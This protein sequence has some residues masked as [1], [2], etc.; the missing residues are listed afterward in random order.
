MAGGGGYN[1]GFLATPRAVVPTPVESLE[2]FRVATNNAGAEFTRSAGAEVQMVT[3]RG[4]NS[5]HGAGYW[6]HQ[7]DELNA[8]NWF[9]N[10]G[11]W[12]PTV[13]PIENPEW[14]D[15]RYG[16]KI[17][18][19]IWKNRTFFFLHEEER[20]FFTQAV[21]SRLVPTAAL[22]AGILEF[23][24]PAT[25]NIV[26]F[27]LNA[28]PT[29]DPGAVAGDPNAGPTIP[30]SGLDLRFPCGSTGAAGL[31]VNV[32]PA[33]A[34]TWNIMPLPND[35]SGG[36]G[37]R[38]A[39][40][41]APEANTSNEHFAVLR[42]DHKINDKWDFMA[43]YR[44]SV[45][46]IQPPNTQEDIS[47]TASGCKKG[48]VCALANRP[49]QPRYLVTGVTGRL[50]PNLVNEFHFDWLR[51]WWSWIAPGARIPVIDPSLSDTALQIWQES[52]V[53]GLV[54]INVDTQNARQRVWNGQDYTFNDN[55]SW[56]KGKHAWSFGGRAQLQ[57]FLHVRD[58]KVVGGLTTPIYY[59]VRGGQFLDIGGIPITSDVRSS[60]RSTYRRAYI[61]ALG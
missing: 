39:N 4:T 16:G 56:I 1:T 40:F 37:L 50:T 59:V 48:V 10:N 5:W 58:D 46:A 18:G 13:A 43:S 20:H 14:R 36:D 26:P 53:N 41:T 38:T 61:S 24:D 55:L 2:E 44:Y 25:G 12:Y 54:P 3:K 22:R 33:I 8:N 60:D 7:N 28:V 35:F 57:H 21:F 11:F 29:V 23:R 30:R 17:G 6:Y 47:G 31:G 45:S 27:N 19:P 15:N 34:A 32:S 51:H 42:L 49:L 52:R 9:R